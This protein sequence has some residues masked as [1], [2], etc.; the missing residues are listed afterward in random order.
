MADVD[1]SVLVL[2]TVPSL[3]WQ[4][5]RC[6]RRA[7]HPCQPCKASALPASDSGQFSN[8]LA[9]DARAMLLAQDGRHR[10]APL[11]A[12]PSASLILTLQDKWNLTRLSAALGL[13]IPDTTR[14]NDM[15]ELLANQLVYPIVTK[16]L[17]GGTGRGPQLHRSRQALARRQ[18]ATPFPLLA[19]SFV[20]GRDVGATFLAAQG[21][22]VAC[23]VFRH[24]RR[25]VRT[26]YPSVRVREYVQRLADGCRYSGV[27]HLRLRYDPARDSYAIVGLDAGFPAS[28]LYAERAGINYPDLLLRLADLA[29]EE[30]AS[31]RHGRTRLSSYERIMVYC[32][33]DR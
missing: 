6:L 16:P 14:A 3:T 23:S 13:P 31:P 32:L 15:A 11:C 10:R 1:P 2:G 17:H 7:G 20:P 21:R 25:G 19:Q 30:V 8:I 4:A 12:M 22:V 33:K 5:T 27:G 18:P 26:F 29:R 28:L 24:T 9:V